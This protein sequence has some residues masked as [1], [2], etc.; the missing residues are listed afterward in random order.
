M[1]L[2]QSVVFGAVI[3]ACEILPVSASGHLAIL[4]ALLRA[5]A[6]TPLFFCLVYLALAAALCIAC[7]QELATLRRSDPRSRRML[8]FLALGSLPLLLAP[9]LRNALAALTGSLLLVSLFMLVNG[10]LLFFADRLGGGEKDES[11]MTL[12]DALLTGL[13]Q[14]LSVL[15]G[16]SRISIALSVSLARELQPA[17]ALKYALLLSIPALLGASVLSLAN[18]LALP[19]AWSELPIAFVGAVIAGLT[20]FAAVSCLQKV[21]RKAGL[22]GFAYYIWGAGL[23]A[24]FLALIS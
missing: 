6:P 1:S 13:G 11:A 14:L 24:L 10:L 16:F 2:L 5:D 18:A 7:R 17:C 20:G 3:G 9:L 22:G 12:S 8:W 15:P 19:L 4:Q 23:V 21:V